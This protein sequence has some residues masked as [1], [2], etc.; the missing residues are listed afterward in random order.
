MNTNLLQQPYDAV[1]ERSSRGATGA[2]RELAHFSYG[3]GL[4]YSV[5][6]SENFKY[7]IAYIRFGRVNRIQDTRILK[8]KKTKS[9]QSPKHLF[10]IPRNFLPFYKVNI[11]LLAPSRGKSDN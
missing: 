7:N 10:F 6:F 2:P 4:L 9:H 1:P 5:H 8:L 3:H 11:A